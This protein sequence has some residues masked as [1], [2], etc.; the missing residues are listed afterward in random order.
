MYK[1]EVYHYREAWFKGDLEDEEVLLRSELFKTRKSAKDYIESKV[2]GKINVVK[3]YHK[4][5]EPSYV[6]YFTGYKWQ[7]EN[8]GETCHEY[9]TYKLEKVKAR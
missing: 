1:V 3:R 9:Y 6:H 5:D 4:G 2:K 7:H 8:T